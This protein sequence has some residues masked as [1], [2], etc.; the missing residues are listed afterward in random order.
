VFLTDCSWTWGQVDMLDE[1]PLTADQVRP[2]II[3]YLG[4]TPLSI[5]IWPLSVSQP[6]HCRP[7]AWH[8]TAPVPS[9]PFAVLTML[10]AFLSFVW[11]GAVV[12]RVAVQRAPAQ[13]PAVPH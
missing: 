12:L 13:R 7:S 10:S 6:K 4:L 1:A 5:H 11:S 8:D 2:L 9:R 3:P